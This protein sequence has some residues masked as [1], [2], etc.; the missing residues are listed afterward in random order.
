MSSWKFIESPPERPDAGSM[1]AI[2]R[3]S[4]PF[5]A[6]QA[7]E[8]PR[9]RRGQDVSR[10]VRM[11]ELPGAGAQ[12][13]LRQRDDVA[14]GVARLV[15]QALELAERGV[16]AGQNFRGVLDLPVDDARLRLEG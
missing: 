10:A 14:A 11:G 7:V 6:A 15:D 2:A 4:L 8:H 9:H 1:S 13:V 5:G 16:D 3:S 12:G